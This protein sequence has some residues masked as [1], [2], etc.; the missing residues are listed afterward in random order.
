MNLKEIRVVR[1]LRQDE[2]AAKLGVK[3]SSV[4]KYESG[5]QSIPAKRLKA[6]ADVL[7]VSIGTL[8]SEEDLLI[9]KDG[10][11]ISSK[12]VIFSEESVDNIDEAVLKELLE[13]FNNHD[14]KWQRRALGTLKLNS[15]LSEEALEMIKAI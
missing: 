3:K 6:I 11:I 5:A 12:D 13:V 9:K 15:I 1:G 2:L 14:V 10:T 7:D 4:C 8:T